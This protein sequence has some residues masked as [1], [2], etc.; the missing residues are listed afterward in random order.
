VLAHAA[1]FTALTGLGFGIVPAVRAGGRA[2]LG[3]LRGRSGARKQRYRAVLVAIEVAASVVLLVRGAADPRDA[4]RAIGRSRLPERRRA[5]AAHGP[6]EVGI[7]DGRK[8]EQFYREVLTEVRHLPGV[9]SAAYTTGLPMVFGGGIARV[10]LPG[11]EVRSDGDY[12]V[13]RRYITPR[14]FR[15]L[16]IPLL[17][18]R[19]FRGRRRE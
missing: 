19:D 4:A 2:V 7:R 14:F 10:V 3:A 6:A 15:T 9:V 1:L 5:H 17:S 8:R 16:G 13:S 11:Q 18:G 12:S